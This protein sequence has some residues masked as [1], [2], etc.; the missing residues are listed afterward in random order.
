V[1]LDEC[2]VVEV[3]AD[4][5]RVV[6]VRCLRHGRP[7]RIA[8]DLFV[9]AAGA[10]YSPAILLRSRASHWPNGVANGSR[11]V[12]RNLM[13][14][15]VD[16]YAVFPRARPAMHGNA[17][18]LGCGD[19]TQGIEGV[20][21]SL[22]SF[23]RMPPARVIFADVRSDVQAR[24]GVAAAFGVDSLSRIAAPVVDRLLARSLVFATLLED[25][26]YAVNRVFV[27]PIAELSETAIQ[28]HYRIH[29][30][31]FRRIRALR[32]HARRVFKPYRYALIRQAENNRQLAHA[33]GTCRFGDDPG[34]SVLNRDNKAHELDNLF[35]V[36][37]SFFPS[38]G[39]T[40]PALTI[41]AN[42]LRVA[43]RILGQPVVTH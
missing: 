19:F 9:L 1:L 22:Q 27:N 5:R 17:K 28:I 16:L 7:V 21:G 37:A 30:K 42:A 3:E 39:S 11:L 36:D 43:D 31:E 6:A 25:L 32:N 40:N 4:S 24:W 8:A 18:E 41:A 15:Y 38:S 12:G 2:E 34:S 13:R 20:A 23:G 10:L 35:V 29:P 33:C 26:P 14:H